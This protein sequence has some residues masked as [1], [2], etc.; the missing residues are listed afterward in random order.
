MSIRDQLPPVLRGEVAADLSADSRAHLEAL[1]HEAQMERQLPLMR[2][3]CA[4][5]LKQPGA[6]NAVEYLLAAA[7]A[8][9]G[10]MERAHQTLLAVG[11][12]LAA[13]SQWEPL[14]A[15]AE[16]ALALETSAA[17][18]HLLVRAH[19]GLR[20]EPARIEALRRAW[21]LLPDDLELG[22]LLT[23]RLGEA[24]EGDERRMLLAELLPRFAAEPPYAGLEEAALEFAE[25]RDADGLAKLIA[26]LPAL[27]EQG[28]FQ[29]CRQLLEIAFPT[30]AKAKAAGPLHDALRAVATRAIETNGP[31]AGDPFRAAVVESLRQGPAHS[32]PDGAAVIKAAGADDKHKP[33]IG[34]L[35]RFDSI[36]ALPPRRAVMH[37]SFGAGRI[38]ANDAAEVLIDFAQRKGH[39]MPYAAARRT[40]TPIEEDDLRLLRA[41]QP[42]ALKRLREEDP[43]AV[44]ARALKAV[45][46]SGDAQKLKVFLVGSDLVAASDWTP[47][48]RKARAAA[49]KN[50]RIDASR[51]FEQHYRLKPEGGKPETGDTPLPALEPRKSVKTNLGTMR[52]FLSQHPDLESALAQ[53]FGRYLANAMRDE[54]ADRAD[55]ARAGLYIARWYPERADEWADVL[56]T[57]WEAGLAIGD[58]SGEEEQLALLEVSHAAGVEADA[59]LSALDS[60]FAAV[61]DAA[62]RFRTRLDDAGR[63][64][65]RHTLLLHAA[66]YPGAA[67]RLVEEDLS[68]APPAADAWL[69]L[70]AALALIED[71]PKAS[72]A[73]KVLGWLEAGGAFDRMLGGS[74]AP[75]ET[76]LRIRV[77]LRQWRSSDRFLFPALEAVE[78][79]GLAEEADALRASRQQRAE[80]LFENVGQLAEEAKLSVMTRATWERLSRELERLE[81][82]LRTTIPAAIQKARELGDLRE[83]AEYH[84]AKLKQATVSKLVRSLQLRLARARFVDDAAFKDGVAGLGTEITLEGDEEVATYWILGEGE[85]HHGDHVVSFQAPVGRALMGR[86]I[87]DEVQLGEGELRRSYRI[88]SIER[89]LPP[90]EQ[91]PEQ[92]RT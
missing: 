28:A 76:R 2:D 5:R 84:S 48:W 24:G 45:G 61:R 81:R 51:A 79:L 89:R 32:L 52:K 21:S 19:E 68:R 17:A 56:R 35:E 71:R 11:E 57:L 87:G 82:E 91:A 36:A 1:A 12:K 40:L 15:V 50:P 66:R 64:A 23:V 67:L 43:G 62:T 3:E 74:P 29:E 69:V 85:H 7:C 77:L 42:D 22:L 54:D 46:G 59:I 88:V 49:E 14:A 44:I 86:A 6:S 13:A 37:D 58:L 75:D 53:R 30:V 4:G 38:V 27:A 41:T 31:T 70:S 83:N 60:R 18:V 25:H 16:R 34:A 72:V 10:E 55:R 80:K 26:T 33:L 92:T 73:D 90:A 63:A 47:F 65:M 20:E 78:R 8:L 9:H 39:R